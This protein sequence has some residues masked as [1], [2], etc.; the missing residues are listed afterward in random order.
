MGHKNV[1]SIVSL[2][3]RLEQLYSCIFN[4][5]LKRRHMWKFFCLFPVGGCIDANVTIC[6]YVLCVHS[7]ITLL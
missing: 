5:Y 3:H 2:S 6:S 4:T 1:P 7:L